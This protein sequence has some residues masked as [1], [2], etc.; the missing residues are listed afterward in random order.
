M[1][2]NYETL[3]IIY[4]LINE[5]P[6]LVWSLLLQIWYQHVRTILLP[7]LCR[8]TLET[9]ITTCC[10]KIPNRVPLDLIFKDCA[11]LLIMTVIPL[12]VVTKEMCDF[13]VIFSIKLGDEALLLF[14]KAALKK[15]FGEYGQYSWGGC[16]GHNVTQPEERSKGEA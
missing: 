1:A 14:C 10:F 16:Q 15:Y 3:L 9:F 2:V 4:P 13:T 5:S 12:A 6:D 7:C 8:K 11:H